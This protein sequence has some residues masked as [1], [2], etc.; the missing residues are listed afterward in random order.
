M[1]HVTWYTIRAAGITAYLLLFFTVA[2][3][4]I[5]SG[6]GGAWWKGIPILP[7]HRFLTWLMGGFLAVHVLVLL[8]D[9]Y[10]RFSVIEAFVPFAA[11]YEPFWTGVGVLALYLVVLVVASTAVRRELHNLLWYGLHLLSYPAF[12]F[13]TAHGITTGADTRHGWMLALYVVCAA[14]AAALLAVRF[15]RL[16]TGSTDWL[17][18]WGPGVLAGSVFAVMV[19]VLIGSRVGYP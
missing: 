13:A 19:L 1:D 2:T 9:N 15:T 3:G 10:L 16:A 6:P 18:R 12:V 7:L 5:L 4:L 8:V 14:I 11:R 17:E